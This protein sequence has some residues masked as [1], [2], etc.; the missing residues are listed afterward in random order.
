MAARDSRNANNRKTVDTTRHVQRQVS[1]PGGERS[2][3]LY[4]SLGRN[5]DGQQTFREGTWDNNNPYSGVSATNQGK[6]G[7]LPVGAT[8]GGD[9]KTKDGHSAKVVGVDKRWGSGV[10]SSRLDI[11]ETLPDQVKT[12]T[13][14]IQGS[15]MQ[16]LDKRSG[17]DDAQKQRGLKT[18]REGRNK[19]RISLAGDSS[20]G[21]LKGGPNNDRKGNKLKID[22]Q[23]GGQAGLN[24]PR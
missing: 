7:T 9:W 23:G 11:T 17:D 15:R 2:Y 13:D 19:L 1:T 18:K 3:S 8:H 24:V 22:V 20:G 5:K 14:T 12:V 10:Y 6:N 4:G 16:A 21:R